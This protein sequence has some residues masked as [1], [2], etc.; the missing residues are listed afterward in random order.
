VT[1]TSAVRD[2]V[3]A[4][5]ARLVLV[6]EDGAAGQVG[7]VTNLLRHRRIPYRMW[8]TQEELGGAVGAA[9]LSAI[10]IIDDGLAGRLLT[11]LPESEGPADGP[12]SD[13]EG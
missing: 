5:S 12:V 7:K 6:A 9:P 3:R 2:A 8:G 4:G 1:G 13:E 10:A 11:E